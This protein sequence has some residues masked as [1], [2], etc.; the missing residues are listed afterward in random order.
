[1][2][3]NKFSAATAAASLAS[4]AVLGLTAPAFAQTYPPASGGGVS[5]TD[6]TPAPGQAVTVSVGAGTFDPGSSVT[7]SIPEFEISGTVTAAANGGASFTFDVPSGAQPG[8]VSV[9]FS[10]TLDGASVDREISF[11]VD[12]AASGGDD[13]GQDDGG[14]QADDDGQSAGG[15]QGGGGQSDRDGGLPFTGSDEL[16]PMAIT[17]IALVGAGAFVVAAARR[18]TS[19]DMPSDLA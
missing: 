12:A 10:G 11:T 7:V 14:G 8:S 13:D 17:G 1:M 15:G 6:T 18:R 5:I 16:V 19:T 2:T 4:V 3:V 9:S